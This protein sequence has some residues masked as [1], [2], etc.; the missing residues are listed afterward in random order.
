[1]S[2]YDADVRRILGKEAY[3][4]MLERVSHGFIGAQYMRDIS[5]QLH[6]IVRGNHLRRVGSGKDCD[7]AEFRRILGD[8]FNQAMCDLDQK[9]ALTRLIS[10]L[11][12]PSV[13]LHPEEK[14]LEQILEE[15]KA[16]NKAVKTIVLLGES[17][18]GKS[19]IGNCLFGLNSTA[20][21]KVSRAADSCT[22]ETKEI[23]GT[24]VTNGSECAIIDTPGLNDPNNE[25]TE[26]IKGIVEFLRRRGWVNSFLVV[27]NSQNPRMHHSF[28]SMLAAFEL[29]FG[30]DFWHHV[31]IVVSSHSALLVK[32]H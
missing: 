18:T 6:P 3:N 5:S 16:K 28:K 20:G 25:D 8:W 12:G 1:M 26:H 29:I 11:R 15:L 10:I 21:F 23:L 22:K 9:T 27:R 17:G 31:I 7:E 13:S 30:K 4:Y 19:S 2:V 24:W 14:R 32:V